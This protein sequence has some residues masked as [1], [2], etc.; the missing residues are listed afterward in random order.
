MMIIMLKEMVSALS[1]CYLP[2]RE[3]YTGPTDEGGGML[4]PR[5]GHLTKYWGAS[6][7]FSVTFHIDNKITSHF[8]L[9]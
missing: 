9:F 3:I 1:R 8:P 2:G 5:G 7:L 6:L 4:L